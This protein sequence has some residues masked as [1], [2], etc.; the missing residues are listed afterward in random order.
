[1]NRDEQ[2]NG[3]IG[4]R[5]VNSKTRFVKKKDWYN[6]APNCKDQEPTPKISIVEVILL[7]GIII[8]IIMRIT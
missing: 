2:Y 7:M 8:M 5:Y 6:L 1:M 4:S 3:S